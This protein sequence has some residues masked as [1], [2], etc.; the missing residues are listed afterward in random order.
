MNALRQ[1]LILLV[2]GGLPAAAAAQAVESPQPQ[3]LRLSV[4]GGLGVS[5][6]AISGQLSA[7][8]HLGQVRER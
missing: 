2:A 1:I 4:S 5:S 7:T 3:P 8:L 6:Q